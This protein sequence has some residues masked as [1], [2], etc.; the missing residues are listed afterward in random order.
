MDK[1]P[2]DQKRANLEDIPLVVHLSSIDF[3][4]N[5][6]HNE[7]IENDGEM[8]G[9]R[10]EQRSVEAGF[11]VENVVTCRFPFFSWERMDVP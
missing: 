8:L 6:H 9:R 7:G 5:G 4:E 10:S 3:V 11:D 1:W 2:Y